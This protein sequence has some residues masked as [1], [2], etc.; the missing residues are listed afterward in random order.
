MPFDCVKVTCDL[1]S[2]LDPDIFKKIPGE[3]SYC[4]EPSWN[5]LKMKF[6]KSNDT[7]RICPG[8][9]WILW[10]KWL[11]MCKKKFG[12]DNNESDESPHYL[13][14][15]DLSDDFKTLQ[16]LNIDPNSIEENMHTY[17]QWKSLRKLLKNELVPSNSQMETS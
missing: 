12:M 2:V 11:E 5:N 6:E 8:I 3:W 1:Y 15:I 9:G 17:F 13:S 10:S 14:N 16:F 4:L 7:I